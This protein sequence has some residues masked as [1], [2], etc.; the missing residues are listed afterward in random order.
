MLF[1]TNLL[2]TIFEK[3]VD[4]IGRV[5]ELL[6]AKVEPVILRSQ[7]QELERLASSKRWKASRI[8]R[9]LLRLIEGR[10]EVI[11]DPG[12]RVDDAILDVSS[13]KGFIVA[14]N[15]R[16]LRKRLRERGVTVIYMK[17]DGKFEVEGYQ[18]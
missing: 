17:S 15:D 9:T 5:E 12:G 2:M 6:D 16:E 11:E 10:F 14:T 18:P 3:P 1:D 8:A 4:V 7:L 13:S